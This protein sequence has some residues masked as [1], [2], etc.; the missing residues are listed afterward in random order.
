MPDSDE[1]VKS[2][3]RCIECG[4]SAEEVH[5]EYGNGIIKISHC[6]SCKQV[7][8]KYVEFDPVIIL[9]DALLFKPQ[10]YRHILF[11]NV[12]SFHWRIS[13]VCL[14]CDAYM[15]WAHS[16]GDSNQ[17]DSRPFLHYA[18]Q[19]DFYAMF[20]VAGLELAG[21]MLGVIGMCWIYAKYTHRDLWLSGY[22][23]LLRALLLSSAGKLLVIPAVIWGENHVFTTYLLTKLF[24]AAASTR[25]VA[26]I[27]DCHHATS[28]LLV[29]CGFT[30]EL[31][32]GQ[33]T[34]VVEKM[35]L[36]G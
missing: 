16:S 26:V 18:L 19:W 22:C 35:L 9:L 3:F 7:V 10:A 4:S 2:Q 6:V 28:L 8:D 24:M 36:P 25:A 31:L 13:I 23:C 17:D 27:L 11:N 34:P 12:I 30:T 14:L 5:R 33:V 20:L 1:R 15:K 29:L 32:L 21:F